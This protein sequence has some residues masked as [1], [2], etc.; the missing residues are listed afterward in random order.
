MVVVPART[1]VTIPV[2]PIVATEGWLLVQ[3]PGTDRSLKGVVAPTHADAEPV[4][5][6]GSG[7]IVTVAV[8]KLSYKAGT[9]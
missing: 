7:M 8:T 9:R 1:P 5:A 6:A 4:M 2:E 3:V